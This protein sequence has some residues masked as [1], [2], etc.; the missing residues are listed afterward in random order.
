[1]NRKLL[2]R[3]AVLMQQAERLLRD[4]G[5]LHLPV[6]LEGLART[7]E[8]VV[9]PMVDSDEGVSGMLVRHGNNLGIRYSTN[10]RN[11]GFQRFSISQSAARA[12]SAEHVVDRGQVVEPEPLHR[13]DVVP[14]DGRIGPDPG[15]R[16]DRFHSY[17]LPPSRFGPLT[18]SI[19]WFGAPVNP[20]PTARQGRGRPG[21]R[22]DGAAND[23]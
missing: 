17:R 6:D 20:D 13:L 21:P 5:F 18:A 10:F 23:P 4:E 9:Q 19:A 22:L 1:M 15:L 14:D 16:K 12:A 11:E 2:A 8:I 7:R 3:Q